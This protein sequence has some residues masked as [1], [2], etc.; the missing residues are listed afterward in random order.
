VKNKNNN[1]VFQGGE[2]EK[3][4]GLG[5]SHRDYFVKPKE[6]FKINVLYK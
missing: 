3:E 6:I 5:F 1:S 2:I 4:K